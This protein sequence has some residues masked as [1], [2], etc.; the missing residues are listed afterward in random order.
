MIVC[1]HCQEALTVA[2][3]LERGTFSWPE[4]S[5]FWLLCS[6]C[7][8]GSHLRATDGKLAQIRVIGAPGPEWEEVRA[9]DTPGLAVRLDPGFVHVWFQGA[10][11]EYPIL[12]T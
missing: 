4:M 7:N 5:T 1:P 9:V 3:A 11:H 2:Q 12:D 10:H 8:T 6:S